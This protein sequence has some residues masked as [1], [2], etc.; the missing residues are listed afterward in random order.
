MRTAG[1]LGILALMGV[2]LKF[3]ASAEPT[4]RFLINWTG[5]FGL[6]FIGAYLE[7]DDPEAQPDQ[8]IFLGV[9]SLNLQLI[10]GVLYVVTRHAL[11]LW[12][13]HV[14]KFCMDG[15]LLA[16]LFPKMDCLW[17]P[18]LLV[19]YLVTNLDVLLFNG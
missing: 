8:W 6:C 16:M 17:F 4:W 7:L 2:A 12:W 13:S 19:G 14:L 1:I 10:L 18:M 3:L 5:I 15:V 11:L 9:V